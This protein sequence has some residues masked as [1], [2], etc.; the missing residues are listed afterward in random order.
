[1]ISCLWTSSPPPRVVLYS[2]KPIFCFLMLS[3]AVL[4]FALQTIWNTFQN[5]L[6]CQL[7]LTVPGMMLWPPK[8][9]PM[10]LGDE[11][12]ECADDGEHWW[13]AFLRVPP[14]QPR[15]SSCWYEIALSLFWAATIKSLPLSFISFPLDYREKKK[16]LLKILD[17]VLFLSGKT[18]FIAQVCVLP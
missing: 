17:V 11:G 1:M 6:W 3:T 2:S 8:N 4:Q 16:D 7:M 5:A 13:Q 12:R 14:G 10:V 9:L 18:K 15:A